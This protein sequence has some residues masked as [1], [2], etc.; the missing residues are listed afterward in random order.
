MKTRWILGMTLALLTSAACAYPALVGPTGY[1]VQPDATVATGLAVAAD[2]YHASSVMTEDAL[3]L[4]VLY[5][6]GQHYEIG[7]G[8]I[9]LRDNNTWFLN[10]K[11]ATPIALAGAE[12]VVGAQ[13]FNQPAIDDTVTQLYL[14]GDIPAGDRMKF[15]LGLNWTRDDNMDSDCVRFFGGLN[16]MLA[17]KLTVVAD[18]QTKNATFDM[19]MLYAIAV[20]YPLT[21][22]LTG[23]VGV[24]NLDPGWPTTGQSD[25]NLFAGLSFSFNTAE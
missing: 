7:G 2:F 15:S 22:N 25:G 5:G 10:A 11:F 19:D 23:Q 9:S 3:P 24:T 18:V 21:P 8:Y 17:E 4:R 6:G 20:R 12:L 16:V 14:V 1:G 13:Y